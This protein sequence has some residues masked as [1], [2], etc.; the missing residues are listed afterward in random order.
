MREPPPAVQVV[1]RR[2]LIPVAVVELVVI[3]P[4]LDLL[5][6]LQRLLE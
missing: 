4:Q 1:V 6:P 3:E 2:E 5:L